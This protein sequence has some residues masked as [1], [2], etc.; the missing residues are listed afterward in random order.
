M[1]VLSLFDGASCAYQ[2]FVLTAFVVGDTW[3]DVLLQA[4]LDAK[5]GDQ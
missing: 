5:K 2:A 1:K 3:Q 4:T